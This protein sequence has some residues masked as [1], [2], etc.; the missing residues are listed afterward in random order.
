MEYLIDTAAVALRNV[1]NQ[2]W[3]L[4]PPFRSLLG[5]QHVALTHLYNIQCIWL[6]SYG[7]KK[8]YGLVPLNLPF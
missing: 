4:K 5:A 2:F 8:C 3:E 7:S 1:F 6:G